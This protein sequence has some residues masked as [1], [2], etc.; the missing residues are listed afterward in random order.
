M[1]IVG[2]VGSSLLVGPSGASADDSSATVITEPSGAACDTSVSCWQVGLGYPL[3]SLQHW[4]GHRLTTVL[5]PLPASA[6]SNSHTTL[7]GVTCPGPHDCWAVGSLESNDTPGPAP[8]FT[9]HWNGH[10][11]RYVLGPS[12]V[13][14]EAV[15]CASADNC[16]AVGAVDDEQPI[17]APA[18]MHW[19]GK[20]WSRSAVANPAGKTGRPARLS[21]VS[22]VPSGCWAVGL[23]W[24]SADQD[25][26]AVQVVMRRSAGRWTTVAR[27]S[28]SVGGQPAIACPSAASCWAVNGV[29][30][31][32]DRAD[33]NWAMRWDGRHWSQVR[34]ATAHP[35]S[36]LVAV[37]CVNVHDCSAVGVYLAPGRTDLSTLSEALHW[38]GKVWAVVPGP[39]NPP[40][41]SRL[42]GVSCLP[43]RICWTFGD[44]VETRGQAPDE[45]VI[46][47]QVVARWNGRKWT[48]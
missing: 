31:G 6:G 11:W 10:S 17:D 7:N 33:V 34:L 44:S 36:D 47:H 41:A 39:K 8:A 42:A 32:P 19:N 20:V 16:D 48:G 46:V 24:T 12:G 2:L 3:A 26:P 38:N 4:D 5:P 37:S 27:S 29:S 14:P 45:R 23:L 30:P 40:G 35:T 43:D 21:S 13:F 15:A 25:G 18:A 28:V 1:A 9:V 22:C